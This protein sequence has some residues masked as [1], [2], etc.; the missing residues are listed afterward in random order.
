MRLGRV[1]LSWAVATS[2]LGLF[3]TG[4]SAFKHPSP[5]GRCRIS[6]EVAPQTRITAGDP[7]VIFGRLVCHGRANAAG[8]IVRLFH[9][10]RGGSPGFTYIQS[11]TTDANGAYQ[12]QRAD[13]VVETNRIWHVRSQGAQ[14]ANRGVWVA[15]QVKL[16]GPAE[17]TQILTGLAN[18]VTFSG[19]VNPQDVGARVILQRQNALTGNEWRRIDSGVVEANGTFSITHTFIV[20]GNASIRVLVRSQRRNIPSESNVLGYEVSQA[21]NAELTINSSADPVSY[22][23]SATLSGVLQGGANQPVT[24]LARTARQRGFAPVAQTTTDSSGNYTFAAQTPVNSTSYKVQGAGK[25]SSVLFE[26]VKDVL[27]A[28]VSS[29]SIPEGQTLTFT[30]SVAPSHAGHI[31]YVER[32]NASGEGFHVVQVQRLSAESTFSMPYQVYSTGTQVYR[33]YIP[34]GPENESATSQ[35][36]TVLV[37]PVSAA[38]LAPEAPDNSTAPSEGSV[39]GQETANT[40]GGEAP[41]GAGGGRS[42][43]PGGQRR[44]HG[45]R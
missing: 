41:E 10:L 11:T 36:F 29:T 24:L 25:S 27:S 8:Q 42:E 1:A 33:V 34:G 18:K 21:Q 20:P 19:T 5:T 40:E 14:S 16:S 4:A 3:A 7:V 9:H 26:G 31:I 32:Q 44:D 43:G 38:Q 22:G 39:S 2:L 30:G 12:F 13:G 35:L 37:T 45:M 15:A 6:I 17:G 23:Q 28:Q